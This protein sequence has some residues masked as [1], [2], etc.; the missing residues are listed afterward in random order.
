MKMVT[1]TC[2]PETFYEGHVL[3][4]TK[5]HTAYIHARALNY[6][7]L[8]RRRKTRGASDGN[9]GLKIDPPLNTGVTQRLNAM[10]TTE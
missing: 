6:L 5:R 4:T 9:E 2:T 3:G 10:Q 7:R 1:S 8:V